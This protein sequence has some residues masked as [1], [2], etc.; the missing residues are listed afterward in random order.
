MRHGKGV[1]SVIEAS[2]DEV[3]WRGKGD[4]MGA[5]IANMSNKAGRGYVL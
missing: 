2:P 3:S 1:V 5:P 4:L